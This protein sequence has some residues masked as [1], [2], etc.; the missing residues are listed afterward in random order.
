MPAFKQRLARIGATAGVLAASTAAL[1]AVS[2]VSAG[3]AM[4]AVE[5]CKG[6][7]AHGEGSS[8]QG[9]AQGLWITG[10]KTA[11]GC[12]A[13]GEPSVTYTVSSSGTALKAWGAAN[14]KLN[15]T[16]DNFLGSD[17]G[18]TVEQIKKINTAL[19]TK[20][21][22]E[23]SVAPVTQTSVAILINPPGTGSECVLPENDLTNAAL[24]LAFRQPKKVTWTE[25]GATGTKCGEP[26]TRVVRKDSS[27][28]T[29]HL[30]HYLFEINNTKVPCIKNIPAEEEETWEKL[31]NSTEVIKVG[32]EESTR[33]QQ[34]S[35]CSGS[36]IKRPAESGGGE[37]VATVGSTDGS[38]GYAA[39]PDAKGSK[40]N[41]AT[42][43]I[44]KLQNGVKPKTTTPTFADPA[45]GTAANCEGVAYTKPKNLA[46]TTVEFNSTEHN[47]DWSNVYGTSPTRGGELYSICTLTYDIAATN[48]SG[49][50]AN[51]LG[52][53]L[54]GEKVAKTV[55]DYLTYVISSS[56]QSALA[57]KYY[58]ALPTGPAE[59]A[60]KAVAAIK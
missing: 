55:N 54:A 44:V 32:T 8:L 37:V 48:E 59:A 14:E 22:S 15:T 56:G 31:Q 34:W 51:I 9:T 42:T 58:A 18:P 53:T 21:A 41:A 46:G 13:A 40:F 35:E 6:S 28:T 25:L 7:N 27:G 12:P 49:V 3:S 26:V 20:A 2:G 11:A 29:Y 36:S 5:H 60:T 19:G 10:F 38:I 57:G 4:A 45:K 30:K 52:T 1:F 16:T 50:F 33:N 47:L 17:D 23:I 39:L 43:S 24:E